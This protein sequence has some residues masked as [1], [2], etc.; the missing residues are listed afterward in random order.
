MRFSQPSNAM[1]EHYYVFDGNGRLITE[2]K[3]FGENYIELNLQSSGV[4]CF[5]LKD[6]IIKFIKM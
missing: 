3:Y 5:R 1:G 2:G 4:Y 6:E